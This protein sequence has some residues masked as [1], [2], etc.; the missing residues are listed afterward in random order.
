MVDGWIAGCEENYSVE[1]SCYAG[2]NTMNKLQ[3]QRVSD[4]PCYWTEIQTE[5]LEVF[6]IVNIFN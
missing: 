3:K 4:V 5:S 1:V 2:G 6:K